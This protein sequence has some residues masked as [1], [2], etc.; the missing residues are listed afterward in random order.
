[1]ADIK[2]IPP[3]FE[4]NEKDMYHR[5]ADIYFPCC[6]NGIAVQIFVIC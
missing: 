2:T 3:P 1:M 5:N 6:K 4:K